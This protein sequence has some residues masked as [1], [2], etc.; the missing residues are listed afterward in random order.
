VREDLLFEARDLLDSVVLYLAME[1]ERPELPIA[2]EPGY[3]C[4]ITTM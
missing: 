2:F 4:G 3:V 1:N